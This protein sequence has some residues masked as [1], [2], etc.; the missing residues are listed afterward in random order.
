MSSAPKSFKELDFMKITDMTNEELAEWMH[1]KYLEL[2]MANDWE[3][4]AKTHVPFS[5]LPKENKQVMIGLAVKIQN[6][7]VAAITGYKRV[8]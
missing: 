3:V 8:R 7:M 2:S 1:E 4:Q 6:R 5:Q